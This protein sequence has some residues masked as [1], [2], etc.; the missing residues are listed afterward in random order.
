[1]ALGRFEIERAAERVLADYDAGHVNEIFA[2]RGTEWLTVEDAYEVQRAVAELR[3]AR[4]EQCLGYKVGC[5]SPTIQKQ[6]GLQEPVRGYIWK[7]E[8]LTSGSKLRCES[9]RREGGRF[10]NFAIE[11][12]IA[13][14]LARDISPG[15]H[16]D[17]LL[18][19]V[20]A[21]FPV[22]ELHNYVF[23]GPL[24]TSQ[25]LVAGNAMHA[26]FV[27][28]TFPASSL[29]QLTN[30]AKIEIKINGD[31]VEAKSVAEIPGGPLGSVRWLASSL[32]RTKGALKA[33]E[34]VLT[35]S[36]GKLIPIVANSLIIVTCQ[37][38]QV[39]LTIESPMATWGS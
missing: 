28:P 25:E 16:D 35:G 17:S 38:Q 27:A 8:L 6:F 1:M 23:R 18:A 37:G 15:A 13:L 24:P 30:Q 29:L 12:E 7:S 4:G 3:R 10:V 21:W 31:L 26:G 2:D 36:P 32:A 14:R 19:S 33:G 5:L 39:E 34:I 22:I 11:G 9:K 20:E